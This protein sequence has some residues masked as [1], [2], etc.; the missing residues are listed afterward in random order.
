MFNI[1]ITHPQFK[2]ICGFSNIVRIC[3]QVITYI[4]RVKPVY[5]SKLYIKNNL[6]NYKSII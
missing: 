1:V 6:T 2:L 4:Y 3:K 5:S